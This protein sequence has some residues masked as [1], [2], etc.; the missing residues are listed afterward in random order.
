MDCSTE[1]NWESMM[2]CFRETKCKNCKENLQKRVD[3]LCDESFPE[4]SPFRGKYRTTSWAT[5]NTESE[6][7]FELGCYH[8][9]S[10]RLGPLKFSEQNMLFKKSLEY[11]F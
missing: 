1:K 8:I 3:F 10:N 9:K 4:D 11:K 5:F 2:Y 7:T 6:F